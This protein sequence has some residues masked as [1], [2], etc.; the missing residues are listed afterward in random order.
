MTKYKQAMRLGKDKSHQ[1]DNPNHSKNDEKG[2]HQAR[3]LE[4][5]YQI[6]DCQN[7]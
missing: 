4:W 2:H 6:C 7:G 5:A 3:N 1:F